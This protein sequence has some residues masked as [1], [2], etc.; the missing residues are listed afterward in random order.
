[1]PER[2]QKPEP[3]LQ[4]L[5]GQKVQ[6]P[7]T[8]WLS[9]AETSGDLHGAELIHALRKRS[10]EAKF[11]GAGG[12]EMQRAG[13]EPMVHIRELSLMGL[14]EVIPAL[15]RVL[16]IFGRVKKGLQDHCPTCVILIDAP[17]FNFRVAKMAGRLNIPVFYYI[18]PQVWAWRTSRVN[19]LRRHVQQ[20]LCI[21]PF[22]KDFFGTRNVDVEYV[23]HPLL[24]QMDLD[25]LDAIAAEEHVIGLMPGSR[26]REISTLMPEFALAAR[27]IHQASPASDFLI[28]QAPN[29]DQAALRNFWPKD[30]PCRFIPFEQRYAEMRSCWF[31]LTASGTAS[32]EC[33]LLQVPALVA[34]KLSLVSYLIGRL[35]IRVPY[36]SLPNL[37]LGRQGLPEFIQ[38]QACGENLGQAALEWVR[39][40]E[41]RA[42][43]QGKIM[44]VREILG[45]HQASEK[46][47]DVILRRLGSYEA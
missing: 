34:Y 40:P 22:E 5:P 36:I 9:A 45:R 2:T 23:G 29:I 37:I 1:M 6:Q 39:H 24:E 33:A 21:L 46:T 3:Q 7:A 15:P 27:I 8:F 28:F 13:L 25:S 32:L 41:Q 4:P 10:P 20:V 42:A 12:D 11:V 18:S 31:I 35:V 38:S 14:T 16:R 47:A 44:A 26:H 17:D 19:F 30:L 43:V